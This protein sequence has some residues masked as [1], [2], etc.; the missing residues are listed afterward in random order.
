MHELVPQ[1]ITSLHSD[2][3]TVFLRSFSFSEALGETL[4]VCLRRRL[5][6]SSL[7]AW[8][9]KTAKW[10]PDPAAVKWDES[11]ALDHNSVQRI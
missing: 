7:I 5:F 3:L 9:L 6:A 11:P 2:T 10:F 1:S 8:A 4:V